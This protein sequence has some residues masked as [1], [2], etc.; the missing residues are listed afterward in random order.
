MIHVERKAKAVWYGAMINGHGTV[1]T[2]SGIL[3]AAPYSFES[4]FKGAYG[5][6]PEELLS[7]SLASGFTMKLSLVMGL[8][9]IV[10]ERLETDCTL[11]WEDGHITGAHLDLQAKVA[12]IT[13]DEFQAFAHEAK[14]NSPVCCNSKTH[15]SMVAVLR[16]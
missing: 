8:A 12:G 14:E 9:G 3:N 1:S 13:D 5:T 6:N 10:P 15:I 7:L 4:S 2:E 11:F 16:S